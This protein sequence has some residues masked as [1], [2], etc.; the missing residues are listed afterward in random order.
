MRL[1]FLALLAASIVSAAPALADPA[2]TTAMP[3]IRASVIG[4]EMVVRLQQG[5]LGASR[6]LS[7]RTLAIVARDASGVVVYET[8]AV[9]ARR[10]TYTHIP[11]TASLKSA[12]TVMVT[13]R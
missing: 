13:I 6:S 4:D 5:V 7:P 12:S 2:I 11:V 10:V 8:K 9:I 3:A 1:S